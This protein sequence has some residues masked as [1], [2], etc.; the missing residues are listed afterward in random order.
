MASGGGARIARYDRPVRQPRLTGP[1]ICPPVGR[2]PSFAVRRFLRRKAGIDVHRVPPGNRD[3]TLRPL[4]K[5][6]GP[7]ELDERFNRIVDAGI[8]ACGAGPAGEDEGSKIQRHKLFNLVHALD[9][10]AGIDGPIA[11]CGCYLGLSA[12]VTCSYLRDE[13]IEK[14]EGYHVFDS[15]EGI[16][17]LGEKDGVGDPNIPVG[18]K[19]RGAGMF[20]GTLEQ[21]R[22]TLTDF[23][24]VAYHPG[25][26]PDSFADAPDGPYRFVY[27]D[28]DVYQPTKDALDFFHPR[29]ASGGVILCDDYGALRWPGIRDAVESVAASRKARVLR[30]ASCQALVFSS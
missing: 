13:G 8:Q 10:T 11:E 6:S 22:S 17:A 24:S 14:G 30:L 27:L 16:S 15:F 23:P 5:S 21:V 26:I 4:T 2:S 12:F 19:K 28:M 25:W 20:K 1:G 7:A 18:K 9:I 29:L 3:H